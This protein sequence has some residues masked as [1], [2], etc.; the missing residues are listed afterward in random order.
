VTKL[1][2]NITIKKVGNEIDKITTKGNLE[3]ES[4][5]ISELI[6]N[7]TGCSVEK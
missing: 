1:N 2:A 7:N 5:K 4:K 6:T 3:C